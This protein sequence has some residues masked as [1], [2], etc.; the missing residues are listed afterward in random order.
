M[1]VNSNH[2]VGVTYYDFREL[3]STNTTTLPTDYWI[4]TFSPAQVVSGGIDTGVP[5]THVGGPFNMLAAPFAAGFFVG[6]YEGLTA[7]GTSFHPF[8][9]QVNCN[10]FSCAQTLTSNRTDVFT[11]GT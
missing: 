10:D 7:I 11:S 5:D 8:F 6:D 1:A 3:T 4:K 2:T 9:V